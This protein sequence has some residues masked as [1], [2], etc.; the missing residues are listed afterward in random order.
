MQRLRSVRSARRWP[1]DESKHTRCA[2][3][4]LGSIAQKTNITEIR[5]VLDQIANQLDIK[6]V[7]SFFFLLH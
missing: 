5:S 7:S 3:R 2:L 4:A 1:S 6:E